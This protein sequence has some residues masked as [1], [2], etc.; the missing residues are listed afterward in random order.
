M[1]HWIGRAARVLVLDGSREPIEPM[2]IASLGANVK[3]VHLPKSIEERF[4]YA[5]AKLDTK[6]VMLLGDDDMAI[7]SG[8]ASCVS[9]LESDQELVA[10]SGRC[11][12]FEWYRETILGRPGYL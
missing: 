4:E 7:P 1:R 11:L 8:V 3:Y 2:L 5:H 6:Y 10:C 12:M 9:T